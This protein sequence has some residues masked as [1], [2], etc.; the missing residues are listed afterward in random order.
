MGF[1]ILEDEVPKEW[2]CQCWD[3]KDEAEN[4]D[5]DWG[6]SCRF[7][8]LVRGDHSEDGAGK[9]EYGDPYGVVDIEEA[10]QPIDK[11]RVEGGEANKEDA[12]SSGRLWVHTQA[13]ERWVVDGA[14]AE[15]KRTCNKSTDKA[16]AY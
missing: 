5:H 4:P 12:S 1:L 9:W 7:N 14:T 3:D 11:A 2:C 8:N 6:L 13:E 15:A 16:N 10:I